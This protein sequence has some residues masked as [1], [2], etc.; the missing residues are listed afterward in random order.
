MR[1]SL[2]T[3]LALTLFAC[4]GV[5][6]SAAPPT[7]PGEVEPP[8]PEPEKCEPGSTEVPKLLRVS[9]HEYR[10]MLSDVLEVDVP[11]A[12][13]ARWMPIAAVYGFDTMSESRLDGQALTTQLETAEQLAQLVLATPKLT[14]HCPMPRAPVP[15]ACTSKV[16]YSSRIDF[17][18]AQGRDC[19]AYLD[20]GGTP[21]IFDNTRALWRK[22]PDQTA[23]IWANG[24]HPGSTVDPVLR[25]KGPLDGTVTLT[26]QF[27]DADP[28]GGD[29]VTV[30][31]RR[32]GVALWTRALAN[33]SAAAT[34]TLTSPVSR[35]DTFDFVVNR[36][37]DPS[38][39]TTAFEATLSYAPTPL[40]ASWGWDNCAAPLISRL[41]SRAFR[42]PIRPD[43]LADYQQLFE[44][45]KQGA[46]QAGFAEPV[47]EALSAVVQAVVLSPNFVF[48]PE[49]VPGGLDP[50]ERAFGTASRL[51][52]YFRGSVP[53]DELWQ[54]AGT[55]QLSSLSAVR[56]QA[57]RLLDADAD[58]F[59][60]H[61]AGQ[62]LDFR[63]SV[64]VG[65]LTAS[66]KAESAGVFREVLTTDLPPQRLLEPG[67]TFVDATLAYHYGLSGSG[68]VM[69]SARG[70][71]L[72]Q[73]EFL[74]HT[75]NGSE[76]RRPI[77]RGLWTLT[78]LM[79]RSLPRIDAATLAEIQQSVGGIDRSL[80]LSKQMELHRQSGTRC[81]GC[82]SMMDPIGLALEKYDKQGL[83]RDAY[84]NGAP[85]TNDLLL[86]GVSVK[87][88]HEL[89]AALVASPEFDACVAKNLLT[90][91]LNRG[92]TREELCVAEQLARPLD[93]SKPT[94]KT[95]TLE[96]MLR[97]MQLTGS[98]P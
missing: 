3:L 60:S 85:I 72:T 48:K 23:L 25:W 1:L 75:A 84:A 82:H 49:L 18:D 57:A 34:F 77:H 51:A 24:M 36:N 92:P 93:G 20:S 70:G 28:G 13:F 90:F 33:A 52:L 21:M 80:P 42:R 19:W 86:D 7:T 38:W 94:L 63:D 81:A 59:T 96:A 69:T 46:A 50:Q 65:P 16:S 31:I 87:D 64:D 27:Q 14:A 53:D 5:L 41:A 91:A 39:D 89:T 11:P 61:F 79:C 37:A 22:E 10:Q 74:I 62:W 9:N 73:G 47:D 12:L 35:D 71:L 54:L 8:P 29:G 66:L 56:A 83:W 67:F 76:F 95:M 30:T 6:S 2:V 40:K 68:K 4:E 58:R 43:E 17:S 15:P 88:P 32:N 98:A 55:G 78:R 45:S 26:G 97:A 44:S